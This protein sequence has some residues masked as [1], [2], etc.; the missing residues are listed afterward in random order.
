MFTGLIEEV[1]K[2]AGIEIRGSSVRLLV[3]TAIP[4][5]E[6][7]LGDSI[8]VNGVCLTVSEKGNG[9][10]FFDVSPETVDR[11]SLKSLKYG[12]KVN[13]ERAL[14]FSDRIGGHLVTGHVDCVATVT[15][16]REVSGNIGFTFHIPSKF[17][18]FMVEKGSVAIDGISLTVNAI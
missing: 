8:S 18:R 11:T 9:I 17:S 7:N 5:A 14:R 6:I 1:G 13:L 2:V 3:E 15:D 10:A 4:V 12:S 16:R